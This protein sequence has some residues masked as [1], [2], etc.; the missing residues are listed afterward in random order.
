MHELAVS[1]GILGVAIDAA[2]QAGAKSVT[3]IDLVIGDLS[4][5][6]DDSVQF[7][8]D[9]ISRNTLAEGAVLNF[10]R[11]P[12][13]VVCWD[14][15]GT[16]VVRSSL[17]AACPLCGGSNLLVENGREFYVESIEVED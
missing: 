14:C 7:H 16:S 15:T 17:P 5:I 11:E 10:R 8:F 12:A 1:R 6:V 3:A 13:S 4:S 9:I 2:Q